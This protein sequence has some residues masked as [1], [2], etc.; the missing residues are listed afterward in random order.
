MHLGY[1]APSILLSIPDWHPPRAAAWEP[2]WITARMLY[3][4]VFETKSGQRQTGSHLKQPPYGCIHVG[5]MMSRH[6]VA[7]TRERHTVTAWSALRP[8]VSIEL[9]R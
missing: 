8:D 9:K 4:L 1:T 5:F 2:Q 3:T 7:C 6:R